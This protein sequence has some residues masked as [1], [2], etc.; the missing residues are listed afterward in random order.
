MPDCIAVIAQ[1]LSQIQDALEDMT[2]SRWVR[3][4]A[5]RADA[6]EKVLESWSRIQPSIAQQE[7]LLDNVMSLH[8]EVVARSGVRPVAEGFTR[9]DCG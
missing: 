4:V 6:F 2:S 8:A 5:A 9:A 3:E 7:A 1:G